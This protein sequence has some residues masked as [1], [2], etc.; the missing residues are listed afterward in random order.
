M[1]TEVL[2]ILMYLFETYLDNEESEIPS[3]ESIRNELDKI[4]FQETKVTKAFDWLDDLSVLKDDFAYK[5]ELESHSIRLF[6]P[7]EMDKLDKD[8]RGILLHMFELGVISPGQ[9]ELIIDKALA[10]DI[11]HIDQEQ[12]KWVVLMVLFN[13][14]DAVGAFT[15]VQDLLYEDT[16]TVH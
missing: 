5:D 14:P 11:A 6:S 3:E 4:G 13:L 12:M 9:R 16:P 2:D 1:N 15:W 7:F 10:L 8:A